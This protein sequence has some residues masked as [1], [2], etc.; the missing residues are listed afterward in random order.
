MGSVRPT[1]GGGWSR[2]APW[3]ASAGV[4]ARDRISRGLL[5]L[6]EELE[7]WGGGGFGGE[8]VPPPLSFVAGPGVVGFYVSR[9]GA[10]A[11]SAAGSLQAGVA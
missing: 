2:T 3:G 4:D 8:E 9:R 5:E 10:M 7:G 6:F 1:F 11:S